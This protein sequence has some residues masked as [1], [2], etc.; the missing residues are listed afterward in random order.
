[1]GTGMGGERSDSGRCSEGGTGRLEWDNGSMPSGVD[2]SEP[3]KPNCEGVETGLLRHD[4]MLI[5]REKGGFG[6]GILP[7]WSREGRK[8]DMV[9]FLVGGLA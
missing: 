1:M 3:P 8:Y 2:C 7:W 5:A 6:D 4:E 9:F